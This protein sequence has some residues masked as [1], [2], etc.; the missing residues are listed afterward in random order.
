MIYLM[1]KAAGL[2]LVIVL[3]VFGAILIAVRGFMVLEERFGGNAAALISVG[4]IVWA[5][6]AV[7]FYRDGP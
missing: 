3:G 4:G 5:L 6:L 2:S 7:K 1:A